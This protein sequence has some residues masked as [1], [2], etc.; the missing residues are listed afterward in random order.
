ML[1]AILKEKIS[2]LHK[3]KLYANI[4]ISYYL[5]HFTNTFRKADFNKPCSRLSISYELQS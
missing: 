1:N 4:T 3:S 2:I 5:I